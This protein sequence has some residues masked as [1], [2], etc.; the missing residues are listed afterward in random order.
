MQP[1]LW[2]WSRRVFKRCGLLLCFGLGLTAATAL[3]NSNSLNWD[4]VSGTVTADLQNVRLMELLEDIAGQSGWQVF[5][6]PDDNFQTSA[7]FQNLRTGEA[8]RRLFGSINYAVVP[9]TNGVPRLYVFRTAMQNA[10]RSVTESKTVRKPE[11]RRVPNELVLRLKPG[12]DAEALAKLL[13]GKIVGTIPE[14]NAYRIQFDDEA[15][16]ESARSQLA[17]NP[18]VVG[19]EDNYYVDLPQ[20]PQ[21]LTGLAALSPRLSLDP[22]RADGNNVVVAFVDTALQPLGP[23]EQFVKERISVAGE[24]ALNDGVPTHATAMVSDFYQVIESSGNGSTSVRVISVDVFGATGSANTFNVALGLITAGNQSPYL[25]NA[26]LGGYGDSPV[27][28]DAVQQLSQH[29]IPV[30]A[31]IGNDA[32]TTPFY[33]AAYPEVISVTALQRSGELANYANRG[34]VADLAAPGM[35]VFGYNGL[36]FGSQGTSVSSASAAGVAA[37]IAAATG[38]PWSKIISTLQKTLA[39]PGTG[40]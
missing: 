6:E 11:A 2:G 3:G 15:A 4:R 37:G 5:V 13:G 7:K 17:G 12:T 23:L 39:V 16:T 29:S 38:D 35:V 30:F 10:V 20:A 22:A 34:T 26:S 1:G 36:V 19:M 33:P 9:Q 21:S 14:L 31:A 8:L 25:I 27:L 24:A 32:S 18:E 28:R 40:K